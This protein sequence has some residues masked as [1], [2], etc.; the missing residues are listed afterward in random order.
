M[1]LDPQIISNYSVG[2]AAPLVGMS[3]ST[4][5]RELERIEYTSWS[6]A[7]IWRTPGGHWRLTSKGINSLRRITGQPHL[8]I[9]AE[10]KK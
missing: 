10:K 9:A 2:E 3:K 1:E 8:P 7:G 6:T 5:R 4:V